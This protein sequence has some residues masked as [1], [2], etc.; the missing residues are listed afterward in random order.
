MTSTAA[1][2]PDELRYPIGPFKR[3]TGPLDPAQRKQVIDAIAATPKNLADAV[4]GL[5]DRQLDTPYRPGGWTVRQVVH[6][7]ADSHMNAYIRLKLALTENAP[8]IKTYDEAEWAKLN[9][10]RETPVQVSLTLL[11]ALHDRWERVLRA[12]TNAD[13]ART[14]T[15][16]DHGL[17]TVDS[18]L[19]IYGWHGPHH[20]AHITNLRKREVW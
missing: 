10:S 2:A 8:L 1:K 16:P 20:T 15:H 19:A 13:F 14:L 5:N 18:L 12:M 11:T 6:H 4:R 17:I 7:V 9:D 3:P